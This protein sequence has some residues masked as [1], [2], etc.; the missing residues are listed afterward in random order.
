[1]QRSFFSSIS[2]ALLLFLSCANFALCQEDDDP[3]SLQAQH[4]KDKKDLQKI[5]GELGEVMSDMTDSLQAMSQLEKKLTQTAPAVK[6]FNLVVSEGSWDIFSGT[7]INCLAYSGHLPG[8]IMRVK[9]GQAVRIVVH[10]ELK[11]PTSLQIQGL[12]L[13]HSV[14]GLPREGAGLIGPGQTYAFQ[15]VAKDPGTYFYHPQV[16]H[17]EQQFKGLCGTLIVEPRQ[18]NSRYDVDETMLLEQWTVVP[19]ANAPHRFKIVSPLNSGMPPNAVTYFTVNGKC[20]PAIP[21]LEV[22][23][24][25][26]V[27]LRFINATQQ[28][29]PLYLSGHKFEV[30]AYNGGQMPEGQIQRDT[31][32]LAPGDRL[33][34]EFVADNPGVWSLAS[35]LPQQVTNNGH[36]PGGLACVVRYKDT[37]K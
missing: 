2:L 35:L 18:A 25:S 3:V 30:L 13:P 31:L 4:A 8:P 6:E 29:C 14:A 33:D 19:I 36:F 7:S 11:V 22:R 23:P 17:A 12:R 24:G 20:A 28:I 27:K 34:V 21:A 16:I 32:S 15:F 37:S 5:K 10:N 26:R 9:E 1:M